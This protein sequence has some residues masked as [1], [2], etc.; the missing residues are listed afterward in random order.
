MG[1]SV[2]FLGRYKA[3]PAL[4]PRRSV[5]AAEAGIRSMKEQSKKKV[6]SRQKVNKMI[7]FIFFFSFYYA[8]IE[9]CAREY[10]S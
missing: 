6:K 4:M 3:L 2:L 9:R 10:L 1:V 7:P 8:V 5:V